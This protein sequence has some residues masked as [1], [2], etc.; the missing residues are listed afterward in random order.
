[1]VA[2]KPREAR[3]A[4]GRNWSNYIEHV[5]PVRIEAAENS[6]RHLLGVSIGEGKTFLDVGSGSGV[7]SLA[8]RRMGAIVHSFDL[9]LDSVSATRVLRDRYRPRD[10]SW[11]IEQGSV[12]NLDYITSL[13]EWDIVYS[14]GVLHHTGDLRQAMYN[15]SEAVAE[16]GVLYIA[17]YNDQ[18]WRS[19]AWRRLKKLYNSGPRVARPLLLL[20]TALC[21]WA[22]PVLG[23]LFGCTRKKPVRDDRATAAART[24]SRRRAM[25]RWHD[26]ID[27]TGGYPYEVAAPDEVVR[28]YSDRGFDLERMATSEG[29]LG[30]NEFLFRRPSGSG[31]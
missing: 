27:W 29:G 26:L 21:V 23:R 18:G 31:K 16:G 10:P 4:F 6:L 2:E 20:A 17:I 14:W 7:M 22:P 28:F 30:C 24:R 1:M 11:T 25:S 8:A 15:V 19:V 12:L 13:G 9:D 3:F 5:D